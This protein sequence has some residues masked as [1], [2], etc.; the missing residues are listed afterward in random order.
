[1]SANPPC[2]VRGVVSCAAPDA[3]H[4]RRVRDEVLVAA[5]THHDTAGEAARRELLDRYRPLLWS[6]A[7]RF[8]AHGRSSRDDLV[9]SGVEGLLKAVRDFD[10]ARG[11]PFAAYARAKVHGEMLRWLR[12]TR[13]AVHVPRPLHET[14]MRVR[15]VEGDLASTLGRP[16]SVG[17]VA[18]ALGL[19]DDEVVE[20]LAVGSADRA[21]T[22]ELVR[23]MGVEVD[24]V[25]TDVDLQRALARLPARARV[26]LHRRYWVG[27]TQAEV[28][29]EVGVSQGQV[30][31]IEQRSLAQLRDL[32]GA[33][34]GDGLVSTPRS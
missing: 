18:A 23:A 20:A 6:L 10:A 25:G 13:Y 26:V 19:G 32:L 1:M 24:A 33:E 22:A 9:S 34:F 31:R 17:E 29:R 7:G 16:P 27:A 11:V 14:F 8:A 30:S 21:R 15:Q 4:V 28:A 5:G 3:S 12:D 2:G